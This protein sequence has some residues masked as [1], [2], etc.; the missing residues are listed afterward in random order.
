M[1][2][3]NLVVGTGLN[4]SGGIATVLNMFKKSG[5]FEVENVRVIKTHTNKKFFLGLNQ[6][7]LFFVANVKL[8][9]YLTFYDVGVVHVHMASRGSFTR[10]AL[11]IKISKIFN[12]K[13]L[14]HLHGGGFEKFYNNECSEKKREMIRRIFSL[15]DKVIV[16][17]NSWKVWVDSIVDDPSRVV[18]VYNFVPPLNIPRERVI[19][20]TVL[21]LGKL[22][23]DKGVFDLIEASIGLQKKFPHYKL[24]LG[25]NGN[26]EECKAY[27]KKLGVSDCIQFVG[28]VAGNEKLNLLE[29][30]HIFTLPSYKEGFPMGIIEAMSAGLAIV[31]SKVGG[32]PDAIT[33][34]HDGLLIDA[35]DAEAL[36]ISIGR[37]L[38]D[39]NLSKDLGEKAKQKFNNNFSIDVILPQFSNIYSE[40]NSKVTR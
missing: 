3:I 29:T 17:S 7:F 34:E 20:G 9:F 28:W 21:F 32:I 23:K 5:F 31:A 24:I 40:L 13:V 27:A 14:L 30:S 8:F 15:C 37:L 16:L 26:I 4:E 10:K 22:C 6:L 38:S 18:I 12:V 36:E 39:I 19:P 11:I 25:G 33:T 1:K 2:K 35:G